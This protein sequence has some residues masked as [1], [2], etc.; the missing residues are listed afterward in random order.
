MRKKFTL[1]FAALLAC[2]GVVKA[3]VNNELLSKKITIGADATTLSTNQW[4][5]LYN[6]GRGVCVSEETT[7][8]KMRSTPADDAL[9][10]DVAGMLFKL[11]TVEGQENQYYVES[12][13]GLY[14]NF[15]Q[16]DASTVSNTPIAYEIKTIGENA[17]HFYIKHV[18]GGWIAD[19]QGNG[20]NFVCWEKNTPTTV[21]GNNCYHF[22]PATLTDV[23]LVDVTYNYYVGNEKKHTEVVKNQE[24]GSAVSAPTFGFVSFTAPTG[25]ISASNNTFDIN[26]T[27]EDV[28]V[29]FSTEENPV[30]QI[31]EMHR[32]GGERFWQYNSED[33]KVDV[34]YYT[35]NKFELASNNKLWCFVGDHF[36]FKIY[37]KEAGFE[38][39]LNPTSDNPKMGQANDKWFFAKS[40][41]SEEGNAVCFTSRKT[42]Y[43]NQQNGK[44]G[45]WGDADNGSTCYIYAPSEIVVPAAEALLTSTQVSGVPAG[46]VGTYPSNLVESLD[47]AIKANPTAINDLISLSTIS[48]K[49]NNAKITFGEGYYRLICVAPKKEN[50]GDTNYNTLTYNGANHLVTA[51]RDDKNINQV[52]EFVATD[53]EGKYYLQSPNAAKC[54][55]N[56]TAG[57]YRAQLVER[58]SNEAGKLSVTPYNATQYKVAGS[59]PLFAENHPNEAVPYACAGWDGG[60]NSPSAWYL[61]PISNEEMILCGFVAKV[62]TEYHATLQAAITAA[63]AEETIELIN[64]ITIE[65]AIAVNK[66]VTR[67]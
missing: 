43:M 62:G 59:Y 22:K 58:S 35:N 21:G 11:T 42:T 65:Q 53:T 26:C 61:V 51:P 3:E 13:N 36:G 15:V 55:N 57:S 64:D 8:F 24:E 67:Y 54:L 20:N 41:S 7:A 29:T 56:I 10:Q 5:V 16:N 28:P 32:Y 60:A 39:T 33:P 45:Y 66:R 31:V 19:G 52:F 34:V 14:F 46:A 18:Q 37:N 48:A 25:T 40:T 9:A 47:E 17:G 63:E 38:K 12:G 6:H 23:S 1:L 2:V 27:L 49:V 44:I 50:N 4:Y 30:W